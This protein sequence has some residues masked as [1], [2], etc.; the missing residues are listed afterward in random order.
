VFAGKAVVAEIIVIGAHASAGRREPSPRAGLVAEP[1]VQIRER[2]IEVLE[3]VEVVLAPVEEIHDHV[4][5]GVGV[6]RIQLDPCLRGGL[7]AQARERQESPS[8][9]SKRAPAAGKI[10]TKRQRVELRFDLWNEGLLLGVE[11]LDRHDEAKSCREE[12]TG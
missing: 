4:P 7:F 8:G 10:R 5:S 9:T 1:E 11:G 12:D 2:S 6:I 3:V